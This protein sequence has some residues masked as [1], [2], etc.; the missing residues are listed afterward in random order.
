M[1]TSTSLSNHPQ[2][3]PLRS[4][5][6]YGEDAR[7]D[8][9]GVLNRRKWIVFL[10]LVIGVLLGFL[11][12]YQT[13]AIY[14]SEARI[15]IQPKDPT[16]IRLSSL[17]V[18]PL[19]PDSA[20]LLPTRH[21][22]HIAQPLLIEKC[23]NENK[24]Y[25]LKSFISMSP[26]ET[27][28][29]VLE[30]LEV[31]PDSEDPFL[32]TL[33]FNSLYPED[34]RTVLSALV[35]TYRVELENMFNEETD[36]VVSLLRD[37]HQQFT[38]KYEN[39]VKQLA[40][41]SNEDLVSKLDN[42]G[43]DIHTSAMGEVGPRIAESKLKL[44]ELEA[45]KA[46]VVAAL[47]MGPEAMEK[48]VWLLQQ[49]KYIVLERPRIDTPRINTQEW[50]VARILEAENE[51]RT[52]ELR[53]GPS[54]YRVKSAREMVDSYKAKHQELKE[55]SEVPLS[56]DQIPFD[57]VL[58]R[59]I[60]KLDNEI[61][62]LNE[63]LIE[64]TRAYLEHEKQANYLAKIRQ[65]RA[66]LEQ[67][68][69]FARRL[70]DENNSKILE[71][72]PSGQ[73]AKNRSQKGFIFKH[74]MDASLGELVWPI[75]PIVLALGSLLGS[76]IGF[77]L[78]CLVD[79][80]DKTFHNPDEVIRALTIPLI[81]HIPV[82]SQGK[83][84][85]L[86]NTPIEPIVCTYHRPKSQ[87]AEAFRAVRTALYF[88]A[89]GK[90]STIIQVT[91][92]TPGDGKSTTAANIA[93]SIAQ[94][95]KRVLIV[96]AD[97]RRP[98]VGKIFG[99]ESKE[100]FA[101]VLS[102][103]SFWKDVIFDVEE[104]EGLSCMPCGLKPSN[105][106]ELATSPQVKQLIEQMRAE[107]DFVIIDT[108]PLLAVTDPCPIAT[109]VDGVVLTMRIKKNVRVSAERSVDILRNIGANIV[110]VVVNGVGAQSGY[111]SQYTYGAYR[112]GYSYNG[113]GYGYGYG[114]YYDD[115][116]SKGENSPSPVA[117]LEKKSSS[118]EPVEL[119]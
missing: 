116:K 47:E 109:R 46:R 54:H 22:K 11:Y 76:V 93:V 15:S 68:R 38:L 80:A 49:E 117:L 65:T 21:D 4:H 30:D 35:N 92:P 114:N 13:L 42:F 25:E 44:K 34:A 91:S 112:A 19:H 45:V 69:D 86:E 102:G 26:K 16:S 84:Y 48:E 81:G 87:V 6:E 103:E 88:N 73:L 89:Q 78:G 14:R 104:I 83:R 31:L 39:I 74:Q 70:I 37:M 110:G 33:R 51:L 58:L 119:S 96:D 23:F 40:D 28:E 95:G 108:P 50:L 18:N 32:Y 118:E 107:F 101:T 3:S 5:S 10:G 75:L 56:D 9:W 61:Y 59:S 111:G 27:I 66:D 71:I 94:S 62:G 85:Q 97:M 52:L 82:I 1:N 90:R 57:I 113:Y 43:R 36:D 41:L 63:R 12:H 72:D 105:P 24:L 106:A 67:E 60:E 53:L 2:N 115:R 8:F 17:S 100:G 64:D 77:G 55:A 99:I 20:E 98:R 79:L 29:T 7:F